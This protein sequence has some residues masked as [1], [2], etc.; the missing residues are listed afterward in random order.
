MYVSEIHAKT[1]Q[2]DIKETIH[3]NMAMINNIEV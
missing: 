3:L 1:C 2:A